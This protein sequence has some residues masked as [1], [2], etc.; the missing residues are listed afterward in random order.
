MSPSRLMKSLLAIMF[1]AALAV[2]PILP[3]PAEAQEIRQ[4]GS[5]D[6]WRA[7]MFE[8]DGNRV[9]YMASQPQ[10]DEGDYTRR[11]DIH[12]MVTHRP[13]RGIENE[14]SFIIGYPFQEDSR[15]TVVIDGTEFTLFTHQDTAWAPD[16]A[17]D[18]QLVQ[19]M[20]QGR[21]MIVRGTSAR[22]TDTTDTYSLIGF[23][24]A[25]NAISEAC[26]VS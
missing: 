25:H 9:C 17:T 1:A 19:N 26:G 20:I 22:G 8:E 15:V 11:G 13:E 10:K 21:E 5:Y 6:H 3:A 24:N 7:F 16:S 23:T 14:V 12:A 18:N 2:A 4:L